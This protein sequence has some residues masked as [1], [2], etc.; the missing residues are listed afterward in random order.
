MEKSRGE[1]TVGREGFATQLHEALLQGPPQGGNAGEAARY[2]TQHRNLGL[3]TDDAQA[4]DEGKRVHLRLQQRLRRQEGG[5]GFRNAELPHPVKQPAQLPTVLLPRK[6]DHLPRGEG[7]DRV[8]RRVRRAG[9]DVPQAGGNG[10]GTVLK[11]GG[12]H[13]EGLK[14]A[15]RLLSTICSLLEQ[16]KH[17]ANV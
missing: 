11:L 14:V 1:V 9:H 16:C 12:G 5:Q 7:V 10:I 8:R 3:R 2:A 4:T 17:I 6:V 13:G 15:A